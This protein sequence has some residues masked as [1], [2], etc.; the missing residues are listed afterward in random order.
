M[1]V[2]RYVEVYFLVL[3][4]G[5]YVVAYIML[6]MRWLVAL[7]T[8]PII[9]WS[10]FLIGLTERAVALTLVAWAPR[11]LA[12]FIAG[13][14]LLKFAIGWQRTPLNPRIALGSV[15][16]LIANVVSFAIA[17]AGGLYLND[18]ALAYFGAL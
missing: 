16:A 12:P 7:D 13:W 18:K 17:I 11:Y 15:L 8:R 1:P 4:V 6:L 14:V 9:E 2:Y 3:V 10:G 5:N